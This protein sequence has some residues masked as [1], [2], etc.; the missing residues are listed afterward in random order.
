MKKDDEPS[1]LT[2]R[3]I[4]QTHELKAKEW[5]EL[6]REAIKSSNEYVETHGLPLEKVR[7]F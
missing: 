7:Q 6:N 2:P 4:Q 1:N 5:A 3:E